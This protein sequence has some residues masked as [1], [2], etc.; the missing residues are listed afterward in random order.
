MVSLGKTHTHLFI[1]VILRLVFK[2][3]RP[4]GFSVI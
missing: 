1:S 2:F 4:C 3:L